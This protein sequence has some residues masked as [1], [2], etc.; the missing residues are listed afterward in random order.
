MDKN[1]ALIILWNWVNS[2]GTDSESEF[3]HVSIAE[4]FLVEYTSRNGLIEGDISPL[5]QLFYDLDVAMG[6]ED[7]P[8]DFIIDNNLCRTLLA[9]IKTIVNNFKG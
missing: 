3:E 8:D 4:E 5:R 9:E 7:E 2:G 1:G 6:L